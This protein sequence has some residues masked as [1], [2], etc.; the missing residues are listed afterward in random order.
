MNGI[1]TA[2]T[3][4][5][6]ADATL[7][8]QLPG[9]AHTV[10][11]TDASGGT[12]TLS[13]NGATTSAIAHNALAA[14]VQAALVALATVGAGNVVVTGNA[15]GPWA[16]TFVGTLASTTLALTGNGAALV[17][18][19]AT[20]TVAQRAAVYNTVA[21]APP[22]RYL[23]FTKIVSTPGFSYG[24]VASEQYR[25]QFAVHTQGTS[26]ATINAALARVDALLRFGELTVSGR[27]SW[28]TEKVGDGPAFADADG[29]TLWQSGSADYRVTLGD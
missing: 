25:Y 7:A 29:G 2:L 8:A 24:Q 15:G 3:A 27:T 18:V 17:G 28:G 22:D 21:I 11:A 6:Q 1:D 10:T 13:F 23:V 26:R 12:F 4:L 16:V 20:L 14:T 5:L 9:A 19:G